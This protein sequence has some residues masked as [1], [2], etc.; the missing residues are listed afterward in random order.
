MR[1]N[2]GRLLCFALGALYMAGAAPL[3][4]YG[5]AGKQLLAFVETQIAPLAANFGLPTWVV[6]W[7]VTPLL[8]G[9]VLGLVW[10]IA[11]P[12]VKR[13]RWFLAGIAGYGALWWFVLRGQ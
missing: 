7:T 12:G 3:F 1:E 4:T 6:M 8:A 2:I 9:G 10:K 5:E 11:G 13:F